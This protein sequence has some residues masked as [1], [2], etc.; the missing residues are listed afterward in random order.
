MTKVLLMAVTLTF[1]GAA[2]APKPKEVALLCLPANVYF[3]A[4]NQAWKGKLAVKDVTLNR[5]ESLC[6]TVFAKK[7]FSWTHQQKW[8]TIE[9]FLLDKPQLN[10]LQQKAWEESKKAA[11]S[12]EVVLSKEYR[13]FHATYVS[14]YW[15]GPGVVIGDHKFLKG[16]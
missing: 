5:G 9:S 3:E 14:T 13:H 6:K 2:C 12:S 8:H 4:G 10:K 16:R 15:S 11:Q 1:S 7:Q